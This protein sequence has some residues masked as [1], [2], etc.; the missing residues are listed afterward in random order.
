MATS[1]LPI[2]ADNSFDWATMPI[3]SVKGQ[4]ALLPTGMSGADVLAK[5]NQGAPMDWA[6]MPIGKA[7]IK[8]SASAQTEPKNISPVLSA[9]TNPK[10]S[11]FMGGVNSVLP[12]MPTTTDVLNPAAV[13][14]AGALKS[15]MDTS[16]QAHPV[17]HGLGRVVGSTLLAA[18]PASAAGG[19]V[20]GLLPEATSTLGNL[21]RLALVSGTE[22]AVF[23]GAPTPE[24]GG[25]RLTNTLTG[26]VTGALI[27]PVLGAAGYAGKLGVRGLK[28]LTEAGRESLAR[29]SVGEKLSEL[30]SLGPQNANIPRTPVF[31]DMQLT[32][33]QT[34]GN[35]SILALEKGAFDTPVG[36]SVYQALRNANSKVI[37]SH[38]KELASKIDPDDLTASSSNLSEQISGAKQA[39]LQRQREL[40]GA[41][42]PTGSIYIPKSNVASAYSDALK[43]L[44]P[45]R[46]AFIPSE[47]SNLMDSLPQ[48]IPFN[49]FKDL[50][51]VVGQ[52]ARKYQIAGDAN[53]ANA[54][55]KLHEALN[56]Q[57]A[58]M[59]FRTVAGQYLPKDLVT[60]SANAFNRA[61]TF[62]AQYHKI[63]DADPIASL[64]R[65]DR[66][67]VERVAPEEASNALLRA[68]KPQGVTQ[69]QNAFAMSGAQ[70]E[71]NDALQSAL[72]SRW[73]NHAGTPQRDADGNAILSSIKLRN[74]YNKNQA[75]F[76]RAFPNTTSQVLIKRV[77]SAADDNDRIQNFVGT[78]GSPTAL[79]VK[80]QGLL[81]DLL[82][83]VYSP[84]TYESGLEGA[85]LGS[86]LEGKEAIFPWYMGGRLAGYGRQRLARAL[87]PS[88]E[89]VLTEALSNPKFGL[90]LMRQANA[91]NE[92]SLFPKLSKFLLPANAI[93]QGRVH[94]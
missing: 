22:G 30:A 44:G 94:E 7:S 8:A 76:K 21:G 6:T 62:S 45:V 93:V 70:P 54:V 68:T 84:S 17:L 55:G 12:S 28:T 11:A 3:G 48:N 58:N 5:I 92:A 34:T 35:P 36:Q 77:M 25:N 13:Q 88:R 16:A 90:E 59:D 4:E 32:L 20:G 49:V 24:S 80:S 65:L 57:L 15:Y 43:E 37:L 81:N 23:G 78:G 33:G 2:P 31:P 79:K 85:V 73:L 67:G 27:P 41:V 51:G 69:A 86:A 19:V 47:V 50:R 38:A 60:D 1:Q 14:E 82:G 75:L 71:G 10:M 18:A 89:A 74:F 26:A 53:A 72:V 42:D 9:L 66:S 91:R 56:D 64:F 63:F 87:R 46:S 83:H 61:R 39:A 52:A 40:W 29:Q